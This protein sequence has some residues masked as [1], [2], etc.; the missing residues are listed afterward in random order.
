MVFVSVQPDKFLKAE[1]LLSIGGVAR[2]VVRDCL[3][4]SN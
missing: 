2:I 4:S 1:I 3:G